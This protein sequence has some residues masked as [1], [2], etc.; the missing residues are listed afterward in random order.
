MLIALMKKKKQQQQQQKAKPIQNKERLLTTLLL[1]SELLVWGFSFFFSRN[2]S[3]RFSMPFF[4][5][6][7]IFI[8][9]SSSQH[10]SCGLQSLQPYIRSIH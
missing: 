5:F 2:I 9:P 6:I 1:C 10:A 3:I 4:V 7:I 8:S